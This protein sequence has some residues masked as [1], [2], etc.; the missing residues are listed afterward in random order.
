MATNTPL[1]MACTTCSAE[2]GADARFC[3][4][5]G[6]AVFAL[7]PGSVL[8]Q[9]G[10]FGYGCQT[11]AG[12]GSTLAAARVYCPECR[13]LRPLCP[14]YEMDI[15]AFLWALDADAM[16]VLRSLGPLTAAAHFVSERV[17]RPWLESSVNG[18]RLSE[19]QLP[20]VF[21]LAI[22]AARIMA[23]PYLPE[24]Y[25]SGDQMWEAMTLGTDSSAFIV[26][27]SVLTNFKNDD[28]LFMLGR[29]MGHARAGHALWKTVS[30]FISGRG[31]K[32]SIL[33]DGILHALNPAKLAESV[34]DAP[35]MAWARH[36]E[37][38]ADR[39][40]MLVVGKEEVARKVLMSWTLK[41]FPLQAR[42]NADAWL[43]QEAEANDVSRFAEWT[44]SST[45]YLA[46]RLRLMHE[47][48]QSEEQLAWR[49]VIDHWAPPD[50]AAD[51]KPEAPKTA[52]PA[53]AAKRAPPPDDPNSIRLVCVKCNEAM[54]IP[55]S[56]LAG[57][58]PVNVRCPNAACRTV[59][60][61]SPKK[62]APSAPTSTPATA[63]APP[64]SE[65]DTIRLT[66]V[67]C[68]EG[69]RIPRS[70]IAG[71][72][73]VNVR[74]PNAACRAVLAVGT[75]PPE[76]PAPTPPQPPEAMTQDQ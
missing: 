40:G 73:T 68:K 7:A 19:R 22:R 50:P 45:P 27:G 47:F 15:N 48:A 41:S 43:E 42:I 59:L 58:E 67:K 8:P 28:L 4:H 16:N 65:T 63:A 30:Q 62:A 25:V 54:R 29:E 46:G 32:R 74:C 23:L 33:G 66:C 1:M 52:P 11:C 10:A 76:P 21:A 2:L 53:D 44:Q 9:W 26:I 75:K 24:I 14:G 37:I 3:I 57:T 17:G 12:D 70:A 49:A 39:A 18:L 5:C 13:W 31:H 38:T 71:G 60:T 36:S 72:E 51:A 64:A 6:T 69:M 34:I 56:A 20:D 35:L 61:V 55:K